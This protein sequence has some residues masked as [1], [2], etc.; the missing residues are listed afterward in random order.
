MPYAGIS[1]HVR[2]NP[3]NDQE[4]AEL[5]DMLER[6]PKGQQGNLIRSMLI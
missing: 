3:E 6:C 4:S 5:F 2:I 1:Y